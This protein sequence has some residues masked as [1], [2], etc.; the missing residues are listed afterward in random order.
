M[1]GRGTQGKAK[2]N[3]L[4]AIYHRFVYRLS[5]LHTVSGLPVRILWPSEEERSTTLAKVA[6][7]LELVAGYDPQRFAYLLRDVAGIHVLG[8]VG[9][10]G[11]WHGELRLIQLRLSY[12]IARTTTAAEVAATLV[13]EATHARLSRRGF[14]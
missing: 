13:R 5:E 8:E 7:A 14:V 11:A 4:H 3:S 12:V 1:S 10:L 6:K 2:R 9:A